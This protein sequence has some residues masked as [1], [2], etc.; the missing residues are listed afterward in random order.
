M[1]VA[2][3]FSGQFRN[4]QSTFDRW[5]NPNVFDVNQEH[6][7][8][9]F[10]HSWFDN[11][12]VGKVHYAANRNLNTVVASE[13]VPDNIIQQIYTIYNPIRL[14][15]QRQKTFDEKNYN[16]RKLID[17]VPQHGL[18][19]L[20]SIMRSVL[21]KKEYEIENNFVYDVVVCTR[22]DFMLM[23]P[24]AFDIVT[25]EGVY[26]PGHS[27]HGFNVCYAMG[28]SKIMDFYANLYSHV[29][30]VFN[31]GIE[32]CDELLAIRYLEMRGIP[33]FNF[34]IRNNINRGI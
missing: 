21:L 17:A 22:Y 7:I 29:D 18:S 11:Q 23:E 16:E 1:R 19:R 24:F 14:E 32:W 27:P 20:Y 33:T 5:Y 28:K 4:V 15:L 31:S 9:V 30:T 13:P 25:D 10:A 6:Q 34:N 26:H 2:I 12:T 3:C 8:D